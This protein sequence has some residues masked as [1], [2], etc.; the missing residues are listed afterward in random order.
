MFGLIETRLAMSVAISSNRSKKHPENPYLL[1]SQAPAF[2]LLKK[3][4]SLDQ[5]YARRL[6]HDACPS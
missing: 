3:L 5:E 4:E 6:F 2:G 1:V